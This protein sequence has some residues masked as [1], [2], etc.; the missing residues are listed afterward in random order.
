M[1]SCFP[2]PARPRSR[3]GWHPMLVAPPALI[4]N[5][6]VRVGDENSLQG[7]RRA[8]SAF[9]GPAGDKLMKPRP[10]GLY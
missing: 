7:Q 4:F 8:E 6:E 10:A 1:A 3:T 5:S 2:D 9:S